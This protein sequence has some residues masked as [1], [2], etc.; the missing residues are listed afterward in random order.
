MI[1]ATTSTL[2]TISFSRYNNLITREVLDTER[3][4]LLRASKIRSDYYKNSLEYKYKSD[5][6]LYTF[7][8]KRT[9]YGILTRYSETRDYH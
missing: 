2:K 6:E 1:S 8:L 4:P 3:F 7:Y 9:E 5:K